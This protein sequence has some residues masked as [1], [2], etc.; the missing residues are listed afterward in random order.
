MRQS[1][2][3]PWLPRILFPITLAA[4]G[5]LVVAVLVGSLA[6]AGVDASGGWRR[7]LHLFA[8]DAAVRRTALASAAGLSAT[9]WVFFHVGPNTRAPAP[10]PRTPP[11]TDVV[12]A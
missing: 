10:P 12:G 9:A 8:H 11:P 2:R 1:A 7:L 6:G 4:A 5:G 3:E